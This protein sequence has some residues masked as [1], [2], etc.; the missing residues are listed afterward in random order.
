MCQF[1]WATVDI[2]TIH[3]YRLSNVDQ[4][5][6]SKPKIYHNWKIMR[7]GIELMPIKSYTCLL[8]LKICKQLLMIKGVKCFYTKYITKQNNLHT[9]NKQIHTKQ[10]NKQTN[11]LISS[12]TIYID[13]QIYA[14]PLFSP[15]YIWHVC[16]SLTSAPFRVS[17]SLN[18]GPC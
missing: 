15:N 14:T 13:W 9:P 11:S 8:L 2:H 5:H 4:H 7:W 3:S 10:T 6:Y 17:A 18:A 12:E 1:Q 16:K